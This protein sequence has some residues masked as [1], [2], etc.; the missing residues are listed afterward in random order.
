MIKRM[1]IGHRYRVYYCF[2]EDTRCFDII[3]EHLS[4]A[5]VYAEICYRETVISGLGVPGLTFEQIATNAGV[6]RMQFTYSPAWFYAIA[7]RCRV[8]SSEG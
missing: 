7:R 1:H 3:G 6:T 8:D 2:K 5:D 4:R